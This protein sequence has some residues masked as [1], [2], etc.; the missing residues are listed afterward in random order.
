MI[1]HIIIAL[2]I[3]SFPCALYAQQAHESSFDITAGMAYFNV[4]ARSPESAALDSS[5]SFNLGLD[6]Y[7]SLGFATG[8]NWTRWKA[9]EPGKGASSGSREMADALTLPLLLNAIVHF[10]LRDRYYVMPQIC[11]GAGYSWSFFLQPDEKA[12]FGGFTWQALAGL[13]IRPGASVRQDI[14]IEVGYRAASLTTRE[15]H[16]LDLSG[17]VFRAGVRFNLGVL[18]GRQDSDAPTSPQ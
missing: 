18:D 2:I 14:L 13:S 16:G 17:F 5:F 3:A 11:F 4:G 10:D 12:T 9:Y 6:R 8:L 7:F 15:G 1:K